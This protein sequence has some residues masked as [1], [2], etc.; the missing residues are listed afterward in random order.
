MI[1]SQLCRM[2]LNIGFSTGLRRVLDAPV[3]KELLRQPH[4][5]IDVS[6]SVT[7]ESASVRRIRPE[8]FS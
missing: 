5:R 2:W 1:H 6:R 8:G 3:F 4:D 7:A